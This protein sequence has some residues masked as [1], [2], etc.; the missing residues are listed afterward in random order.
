VAVG[1]GADYIDGL[2]IFLDAAL[3]PDAPPYP[4]APF[5]VPQKPL[6]G[7][8]SLALFKALGGDDGLLQHGNPEQGGS[9]VAAA[10]RL[11]EHYMPTW[12][13]EGSLVGPLTGTLDDSFDA[14]FENFLE[15]G[16]FNPDLDGPYRQKLMDS[17]FEVLG[18]LANGSIGANLDSEARGRVAGGL[19]AL[20]DQGFD[21]HADAILADGE[22]R[23]A[24]ANFAVGL[25]FA[26]VP[27]A[28][29]GR[30]AA[31]LVAQGV[32]QGKS[33]VNDTIEQ[34]IQAGED[35]DI[36]RDAAE[37]ANRGELLA[38]FETL[39]L[40][41]EAL[42]RVREYIDKQKESLNDGSKTVGELLRDILTD[43]VIWPDGE[44]VEG[45]DKG[46]DQVQDR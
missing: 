19:I 11:F 32:G 22:S 31:I 44:F 40:P 17:L 3:P 27:G 1:G 16:L 20:V 41:P 15:Q 33:V 6:S 38:A 23:K 29:G 24:W 35:A 10:A 43:S 4:S 18:G 45:V 8:Q 12:V 26:F 7:A 25:A 14:T 30:V 42:S 39:G 13:A 9:G 46:W 36:A 28:P 2:S 21:A 5:T 37:A 34:L